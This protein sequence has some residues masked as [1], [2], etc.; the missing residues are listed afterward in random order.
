MTRA[1]EKAKSRRADA[2]ALATGTVTRAQLA[3]ANAFL[4]AR[5]SHAPLDFRRIRSPR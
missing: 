4:P 1:E 2:R 5:M 3:R